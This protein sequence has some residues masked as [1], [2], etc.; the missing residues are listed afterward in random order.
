MT[1]T[2]NVYSNNSSN[3]AY[4]SPIIWSPQ[5]EQYMYDQSVFM[6]YGVMDARFLNQPGRQGN[7]S[8]ETGYSMGQ[9]TEGVPTP[10]SKI[11]YNQVTITFNGYGDAKQLTDE[12]VLNSFSYILTDIQ[13][14]AIGA[15]IENRESVIVTEL[16]TTTTTGIYPNSRTSST[17]TSADTFN[18]QIIR[19]VRKAM[20]K[21]QAKRCS[22]I[23]ISPDQ[24]ADVL[25]LPNFVNASQYGDNRIIQTGEIGKY[26]G[27]QFRISNFITSATENSIT[28]YKAVALGRRPFVFAPK[29]RFEF[30]FERE[31]RRDRAVTASWWEMFGVSILWEASVTV[32]TTA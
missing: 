12:K 23:V 32:L 17:I 7:Y 6:Q 13:R 25:A 14:N 21:S 11:S 26:I 5:S 20:I 27:I 16:L 4:T 8:L 10:V 30:A 28:V 19:D 18:T 15:M 29:R 2:D 22:A 31:A 3:A 1:V 9:L 24:E